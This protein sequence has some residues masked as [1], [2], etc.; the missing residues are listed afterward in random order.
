MIVE[1]PVGFWEAWSGARYERSGAYPI[2]GGLAPV[3]IDLEKGIGRYVEPN[4]WFN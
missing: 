4:V 2:A 3:A 1:K